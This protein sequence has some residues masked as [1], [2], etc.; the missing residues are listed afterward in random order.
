MFVS[1][2]LKTKAFS[3]DEGKHVMNAISNMC[4]EQ[5]LLAL[6]LLSVAFLKNYNL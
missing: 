2:K 5:I 3:G 6:Q 1:N 4:G